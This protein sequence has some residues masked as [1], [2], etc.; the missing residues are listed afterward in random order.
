MSGNFVD[1]RIKTFLRLKVAFFLKICYHHGNIPPLWIVL[2]VKCFRKGK[3]GDRVSTQ[4]LERYISLYRLT[5]FRVALNYV[6]NYEDAEDI[7]QDAFVKLYTCD[8][9]FA[10]DENVKAWL[11]RVA[12]NLSKNLLKKSRR[13]GDA[14]LTMDIPSEDITDTGLYDCIKQLKPEYSGVIYLFY[15]EGYSVKEIA[16]LCGLTSAAVRTR[17]CRGRERL[18]EMLLKED[19]I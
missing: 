10:A 19:Q 3:G 16:K 6:K 8:D 13:R 7:S 14:E 1:F 18:R 11:I 9:S 5:V 4:E 2:I 15:Y 12:I 17:L